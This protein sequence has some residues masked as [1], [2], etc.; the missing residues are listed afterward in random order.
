MKSLFILLAFVA[1]L[2]FVSNEQYNPPEDPTETS[3]Q[4]SDYDS[5]VLL[6]DIVVVKSLTLTGD[7]GTPF[8][9]TQEGPIYFDA[10]AGG[11]P[12]IEKNSFNTYWQNQPIQYLPAILKNYRPRNKLISSA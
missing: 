8:E 4:I 6:A 12:G 9:G 7:I 11:N 1:S 2:C 10:F 5:P 3:Y